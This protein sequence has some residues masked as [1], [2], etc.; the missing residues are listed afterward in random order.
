M[1]SISRDTRQELLSLLEPLPFLN[2]LEGRD[3]LLANM[4]LSLVNGIKR[5]SA[6]RTDLANIIDACRCASRPAGSDAGANPLKLLIQNACDAAGNAAVVADLLALLAHLPAQPDPPLC[7]YPGLRP[8]QSTDPHFYGRDAEIR[9]LEKSLY[10]NQHFFL[11]IGPSGSGKSSLLAAGLVPRLAHSTYWE[12]GFWQVLLLRP[13]ATP[14]TTLAAHLGDLAQPTQ[15]VA[16]YLAASPPARRLLLIVDQFEELFAAHPGQEDLTRPFIAALQNLWA[17]DS[18]IVLLALRADFFAELMDSPLWPVPPSARVE[19]APLHGTALRQAIRQPAEDEGVDIEESLLERLVADV[20]D[21]P[22]SLPLLQETLVQLWGTMEACTLSLRAYEQMGTAEASGLAVA[23]RRHADAIFAA[24]TPPQQALARRIFLRLI[25]F[26]EGRADTRRQQSEADLRA[27]GDDP[28][29]FDATLQ[30]LADGRLLILS[31]EDAPS[32]QVDLAHEALIACWPILQDWLRDRRL[33]EQIRRRLEDKADEWINLG[34]GDGG[35]LDASELPEA[36]RWLHSPDASDLGASADLI[37]LVQASQAALKQ[38][39][40]RRQLLRLLSVLLI[41]G[42]LVALSVPLRQELL[43]QRARAVKTST[44]ISGQGISFETEEVTNARYRLC[45]EAGQCSVPALQFSTYFSQDTSKVPVTTS[46]TLP[47]TG[48]DAYQAW[49]FC[50]WIDRKL[51]TLSDWEVALQEITPELPLQSSY[52]NL[53]Y[54][55]DDGGRPEAHIEAATSHQP[56]A[57]DGSKDLIGNVWEWT[58]S[59]WPDGPAWGGQANG[60][61]SKLYRVGGS[62]LTGPSALKQSMEEPAAIDYRSDD[63]GFRCVEGGEY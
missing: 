24:L 22:G 58:V 10:D 48:V 17:C 61:P 13:G 5:S 23:L 41:T 57:P 33:A 6:K 18:C 9:S 4:P 27:V 42:V 15:A 54:H 32:R 34:R 20:A 12:R 16:N 45:V 1:G 8:Y 49:S 35:L 19:V 21:Q 30:A 50:K 25:Q 44:P 46:A 2:S 31:G 63:M 29:L 14:L 53:C 47:V 26:G 59:P 52:A 3:L 37:S 28:A 60:A 38:A 55:C 7:P 36:E 11:V 51:P 62:F 56:Q 40:R 39:R 43:R